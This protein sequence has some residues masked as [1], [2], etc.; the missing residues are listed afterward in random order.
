MSVLW[1][2][3]GLWLLTGYGFAQQFHYVSID[4]PCS[5]CPGQIAAQ[6]IANGINSEG[7]I[8]GAFTDAVGLQHGFLLREGRFTTIDFPGAVPWRITR[9]GDIYG[10]LH[11][12]D[13]MNSMFGA[14][15]T[16]SSVL[17]L[18]ANGGELTDSSQ[19]MPNSMN[20]GATPD[21]HLI[22][23]FWAD[24]TGHRRGF[25]VQDGV[26]QSYDVPGSTFTAPWDIN[27]RRQFV[28]TYID[29]TGQRHGFLQRP[30]GSAPI[31]VDYPGAAATIAF[32][33][34]SE[35]VIVGR[36][37]IGGITHGFVAEAVEE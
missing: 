17:S 23:G 11:D 20:N 19:S 6:T 34:N 9:H 3:S 2:V 32:G 28:G 30:N 12:F 33:I 35:G 36:Y 15:W 24:T 21:G 31:N 1:L 16:R 13:F 18:M 25:L 37:T 26:F 5:A 14:V 22:V 27:P 10:C 4:V 8:V 29:G 7:D